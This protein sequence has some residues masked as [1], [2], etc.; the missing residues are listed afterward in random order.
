LESSTHAGAAAGCLISRNYP[1]VP[2]GCLHHSNILVRSN[3]TV[4]AVD[5]D[6]FQVGDG[7]RFQCFVGTELFVPPECANGDEVRASIHFAD[8]AAVWRQALVVPVSSV[9]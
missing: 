2:A 6:S 5:C 1:A 4:A 3:A 8:A 7:S 9:R